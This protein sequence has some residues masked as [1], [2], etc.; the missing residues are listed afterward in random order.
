MGAI[1]LRGAGNLRRR[2]QLRLAATFALFGTLVSLLLSGGIFLAER[3]TSDR[4][5]DE[6]LRA[7]LEDYLARRARN[8]ASLPPATV[9]IRGY[10]YGPGGNYA[11]VPRRV[12]DLPLG[13]YQLVMDG[14]P[15]RISAVDHGG[16]RY[17]MMFNEV[18]QRQRE[19]EF[20]ILLVAGTLAMALVSAALGWWLAGRVLAP[21][22][23]LAKLIS[24][25]QP[26]Q[27]GVAATEFS[28]DEI[29]K[30]ARGVFGEYVKRMHAFISRE[31]AFATDVSHELRTPLSIV[32]GVV[33]LMESDQSLDERERRR[34]DRIRRAVDGMIDIIS[35][36]L[37]IAREETLHQGPA[38]PSDVCDVVRDAIESH[39]HMVGAK[40]TVLLDCRG[41]PQL[42]VESTLLKIVVANLVLN[43]ITNTDAGT[44]AVTVDNDGVTVSDSGRGIS[45]EE[46]DKV[47]QKHFKGADSPGAGIGLSL[48]KR[49][50]DR[51]GWE[52]VIE[53]AVGRGTSA[54]LNYAA[55]R[56]A[57]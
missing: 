32:R 18:R 37:M 46:I 31:Q 44:I 7:E 29:G 39:R 24:T 48:V 1:R 9:S 5:M 23:K 45:K 49:I 41:N 3:Q 47:F 35:A 53:S 40:T 12:Q 17:F 54:R 34:V 38:A 14:V 15:Y 2:L 57:S 30:L 4:L 36:L 19:E 56:A 42:L 55:T 51:N 11:N 13:K 27:A 52:I 8:P 26:E 43:A 10:V 50:C 22:A 25:A 21:V 20:L 28:D 33:E 16:E 6:T